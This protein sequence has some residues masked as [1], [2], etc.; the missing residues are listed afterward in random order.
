MIQGDSIV[1]DIDGWRIKKKKR[2]SNVTFGKTTKRMPHHAK[3]YLISPEPDKVVFNHETNNLSTKSS[4]SDI[5]NHTITLVTSLK[6]SPSK[7]FVS[8]NYQR[9]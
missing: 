9:K 8:G 6:T 7:V 3:G 2:K 4:P 5:V 1:K